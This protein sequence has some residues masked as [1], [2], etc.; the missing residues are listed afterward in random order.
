MKLTTNSVDS[1]AL[2]SIRQ[3][4]WSLGV[5]ES[6]VCA[7]IRNGVLRAVRRRSRL[8]V[9]ARELRRALDGGAR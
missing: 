8:V 7:A 5:S 3:A 1:S 2:L 6:C 4:A 9:P